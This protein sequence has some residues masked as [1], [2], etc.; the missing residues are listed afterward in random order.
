MQLWKSGKV[1]AESTSSNRKGVCGKPHNN[2]ARSISRNCLESWSLIW[3]ESV[4]Q[5]ALTAVEYGANFS[6]ICFGPF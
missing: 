1:N 6:D 3:L 4:P 5:S 2:K